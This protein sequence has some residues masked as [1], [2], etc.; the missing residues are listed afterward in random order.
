MSYTFYRDN[1]FE[2]ITTLNGSGSNGKSVLFGLLTA[3]HGTANGVDITNEEAI[4]KFLSSK[5]SSI[6]VT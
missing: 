2:I 1:P 3:L 6:K 5:P 4:K